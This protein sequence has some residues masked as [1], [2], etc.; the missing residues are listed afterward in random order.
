[1]LKD[2]TGCQAVV[3][4]VRPSIFRGPVK[5]FEAGGPEGWWQG[6]LRFVQESSCTAVRLK[7]Q[8]VGMIS[9]CE[10]LSLPVAG[11]RRRSRSASLV[12]CCRLAVIGVEL[13]IWTRSPWAEREFVSVG[14]ALTLAHSVGTRLALH[15]PQP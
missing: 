14:R 6:W 13:L 1:M 11:E 4:L 3:Q 10:T 9:G 8:S 15:P 12:T 2:Y 7:V 5:R